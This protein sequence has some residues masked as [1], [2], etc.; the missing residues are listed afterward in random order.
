MIDLKYETN[1][2]M[3]KNIETQIH[4]HKISN[5]DDATKN[6]YNDIKSLKEG[7]TISKLNPELYKDFEDLINSNVGLQ[8]KYNTNSRQH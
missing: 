8:S 7:E 6:L 1:P 4:K 2:K 5:I 3:K